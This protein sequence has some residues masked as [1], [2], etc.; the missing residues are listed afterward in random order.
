MERQGNV[1]AFA[2][3]VLHNIISSNPNI[4]IDYNM[5]FS[6]L[7]FLGN[8]RFRFILP[9]IQAKVALV[10]KNECFLITYIADYPMLSF[11][12]VSKLSIT[13]RTANGIPFKISCTFCAIPKTQCIWAWRWKA[14]VREFI[15]QVSTWWHDIKLVTAC[16]NVAGTK[17]GG[18]HNLLS[19]AIV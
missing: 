17:G 8:V 9:T 4:V 10:L 19:D 18:R 16:Y 6:F 1:A 13:A 3:Q 7:S 5:T 15:T 14:W 2:K 12:F 11:S